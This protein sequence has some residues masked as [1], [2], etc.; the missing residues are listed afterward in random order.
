MS[1]F[2]LPDLG[3]GLEEAQ[4]VQWLV[5]VGDTVRLND[6]ICQVETAKALV[7]IPSPFAGTVRILH[8]Q[9]GDTVLVGAP[10]ITIDEA[11]AGAQAA[12]T[13]DDHPAVLV[14]YGSAGPAATF[15]RRR[16]GVAPAAVAPVVEHE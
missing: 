13:D 6:A 11:N 12:V 8:A 4:L 16:R 9:P 14:G 1:Q 3:G 7:D 2:L 10:L 5:Q 15:S